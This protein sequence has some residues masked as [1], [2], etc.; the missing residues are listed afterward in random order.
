MI[1][2]YY[3][4]YSICSEKVLTCLFEKS[5]PFTGHHI[6]LMEFAQVEPYY[7]QIN[8]DGTVPTLIDDGKTVRESTII[9]EYLDEVY[10]QCRL[11]PTDPHARAVMRYWVQR[12]QDVVF[13]AAGMLS[14]KHFIVP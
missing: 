8:P 11:T 7:R 13:P 10:P 9:N 1:H 12:F 4:W 3:S 6:D 14:Q 2:L 5:L